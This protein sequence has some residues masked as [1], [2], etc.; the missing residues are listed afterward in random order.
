[1][2]KIECVVSH[3][4]FNE[5]EEKLRAMG[6]PGLTVSEVKGY[7]NEQT[8]PESYLFLP[9]MKL[10]IYCRDEEVEP[11]IS[12]MLK[13]CRTGQ[14]G[15]GKIAVVELHDLIRIRTKERGNDAV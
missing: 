8:R 2:K 5:L 6:I 9:K 10:E 15:D 13:V 1:M 7:G 11:I 3:K 14:L 12:T 4:K